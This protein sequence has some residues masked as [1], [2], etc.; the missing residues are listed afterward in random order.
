MKDMLY[1]DDSTT[2]LLRTMMSLG[3]TISKA[4]PQIAKED[5]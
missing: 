1:D 5:E 4:S 3:T 2:M